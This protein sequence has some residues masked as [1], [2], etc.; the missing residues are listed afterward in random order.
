MATKNDYIIPNEGLSDGLHHFNFAIG[1]EFIEDN[2]LEE[3]KDISLEVSMNVNKKEKLFVVDLEIEGVIH[4]KCDRCLE[5][6]EL[7]VFYENTFYIK[8]GVNREAELDNE[9][10]ILFFKEGAP[11]IDLT[12]YIYESVI[13]AIPL[14]KVHPDDKDGNITCNSEVMRILHRNNKKNEKNKPI[15]PRWD[16]LKNLDL[17]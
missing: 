11:H 15:D 1:R 16:V 12:Q 9:D 3:L 4:T 6:L 8:V 14:K 10:D 5:N 7:P 13:L 17:E 2:S